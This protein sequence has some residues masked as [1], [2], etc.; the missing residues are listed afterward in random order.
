[1]Q[2]EED[3]LIWYSTEPANT[4]AGLSELWRFRH[5]A[6]ILAV[7]D[8]KVRY[9]QTI[10]GVAWAVL[11]P[12]AQIGVFA[13]LF[14]LLGKTPVKS[15]TPFLVSAMCG[16][17]LWQLFSQS[18]AT[19][20]LSLVENRN[21]V[22]KVYFPRLVLPL[23]SVGGVVV[24]F[25]VGCCLLAAIMAVYRFPPS[26]AVF[27]APFFVLLT[28]LLAIAMASWLAA[29]CSFYRDFQY[30]IPFFL[31]ITFFLSPVVYETR[32]LIPDAWRPMYALNPMAGA[33]DGFRWAMTGEGAF[34]IVTAC[35]SPL[36]AGLLLATGL[37]YFRRVERTVADRI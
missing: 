24:D 17:L 3:D 4:L 20:S 22:T 14:G 33:I 27:A 36:I 6:A 19:A 34:P 9:R 35:A 37:L 29:L 10:I 11:Q 13:L 16:F 30:V 31:Q 25:A 21:L 12:L 28:A 1:M 15:G 26:I 5:L 2:I 7:R 23:S 32:S 18:V 8:I